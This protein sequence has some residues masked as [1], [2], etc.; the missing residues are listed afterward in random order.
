MFDVTRFF[1]SLSLL[2]YDVQ[3]VSSIQ[4]CLCQFSTLL[5]RAA[6][7]GCSSQVEQ[8]MVKA[9]DLQEAEEDSPP[10]LS[11]SF[12]MDPIAFVTNNLT[13]V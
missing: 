12:F 9:E 7:M 4:Y 13:E 3:P 8:I 10:S 5:L 1:T 2:S 11:C 6:N